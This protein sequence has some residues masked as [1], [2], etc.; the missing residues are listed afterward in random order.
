M[1]VADPAVDSWFDAYHNP[2]KELVQAVRR[3]MLDQK[4]RSAGV[5]TPWRR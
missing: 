5:V 2:Q 1:G 4:P 3:A